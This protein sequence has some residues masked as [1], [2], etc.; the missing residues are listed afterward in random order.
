MQEIIYE[1][2]S[3]N[4]RNILCTG[5]GC[6]KAGREMQKWTFKNCISCDDKEDISARK[7]GMCAAWGRLEMHS[8]VV[9]RKS[10]GGC[11]EIGE[12][13]DDLKETSQKY[14]S[15]DGVQKFADLV[16]KQSRQI[17]KWVGDA[18]IMVV[19][20]VKSIWV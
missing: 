16:V 12:H 1:K 6:L 9:L 18:E 15:R 20:S 2:S 11:V 5:G 7:C 17:I 10:V 4:E 3:W 19:S 14:N 13:E 8:K